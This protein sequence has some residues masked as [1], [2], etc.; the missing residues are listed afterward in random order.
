MGSVTHHEKMRSLQKDLRDEVFH[1]AG[2]G[3]VKSID[4]F[5]I[6]VRKNKL[7]K[8]IPYESELYLP[9]TVRM[10]NGALSSPLKHAVISNCIYGN[11]YR[12]LVD[13]MDGCVEK[14]QGVIE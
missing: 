4:V 1:K 5:R 10:M 14:M 9:G 11:D 2:L 13:S 6:A 8:E 3:E 12:E 7:I